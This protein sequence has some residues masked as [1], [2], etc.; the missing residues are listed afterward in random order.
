M[1]GTRQKTINLLEYV[2][3]DVC[4]PMQTTTPSG[5]RFFVTFIDVASGRLA[6]TLLRTKGEVFDNFIIFRR[7]AEKDT[8]RAIRHLRSD[9]GGEYMN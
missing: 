5:E 2:H 4:G 6:V 3:G 7:R 9:G 8:G 1:T